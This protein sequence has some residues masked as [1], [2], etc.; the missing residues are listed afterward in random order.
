M[1]G[2]IQQEDEGCDK[3]QGPPDNKRRSKDGTR[4]SR[5]PSAKEYPLRVELLLPLPDKS[6]QSGRD[7]RTPYDAL[8]DPPL[9]LD[10]SLHQM[11]NTTPGFAEVARA[12]PNGTGGTDPA[13]TPEAATA[14]PPIGMAWAAAPLHGLLSNLFPDI[15]YL[16]RVHLEKH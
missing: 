13:P 5:I 12:D 11:D 9:R 1:T 10:R 3:Q 7:R 15:E 14:C 8:L 2:P 16:A 6:A 4:Q